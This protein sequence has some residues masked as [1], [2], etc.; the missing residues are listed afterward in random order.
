MT[1]KFPVRCA[2][3]L[4]SVL[5][6]GLGACAEAEQSSWP[7]DSLHNLQVLAPDT[8]VEQIVG[9]MKGF[10][11]DLGVRCT[12]CHVGDDPSDLS[13]IDFVS[14]E[15]VEKQET[16]AMLRMVQT[17]NVDSLVNVAGRSNPPVEVGCATCHDG[18]LASMGSPQSYQAAIEA[19]GRALE[20]EPDNDSYKR[21]M[22]LL[23]SGIGAF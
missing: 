10:S 6:V 13:S 16:R 3:L 11:Q 1:R 12:H 9:I 21:L 17:V 15:K 18:A 5:A 20:S 8:S 19:L 4:G 23:R 14:D 7:P 22:E 2:L